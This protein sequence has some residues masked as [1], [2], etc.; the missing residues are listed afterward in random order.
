MRVIRES[1]MPVGGIA[2]VTNLPPDIKDLGA[3]EEFPTI[4]V[5]GRFLVVP[6]RTPPPATD[7]WRGA[8]ISPHATKI[9]PRE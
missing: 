6:D 3:A 7:A 4:I 5:G 9:A 1:N 2:M 8:K